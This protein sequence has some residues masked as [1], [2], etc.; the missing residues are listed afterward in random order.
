MSIFPRRVVQKLINESG[1]FL[2]PS[3][4]GSLVGRLNKPFEANKPIDAFSAEW[5]IVVL[6]AF[7]KIGAVEHEPKCPGSRRP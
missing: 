1:S 2:R 6:S 7:H 4:I 3:Q 5:E